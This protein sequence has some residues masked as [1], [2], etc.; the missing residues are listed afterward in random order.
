MLDLFVAVVLILVILT[1]V[2]GVLS[3]MWDIVI[4]I[5]LGALAG[6]LARA[7]VS[8]P[9]KGG[10]GTDVA[11]GVVGA[12][13]GSLIVRFFRWGAGVT[14]F[15]LHSFLIALLGAIVFLVVARA[16]ARER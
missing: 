1:L 5:I 11:I 7:F 2:M 6:G 3:A 16:L 12:V 13:V 4:A 10:C 9:I 14:G 8:S 15:N